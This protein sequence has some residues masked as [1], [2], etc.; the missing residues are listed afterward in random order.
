LVL[1]SAEG[2]FLPFGD[3]WRQRSATVLIFWSGSCPCVRRY[4]TR[5]DDLLERYPRDRVRVVAIS[6]NAGESFEEVLRIAKER[7][8]R[9]PIYR[10]ESGQVAR[11]VDAQSTPTVVVLDGEGR[12][13]FRGWMDNERLPEDP[14]REPWL[15]LALRGLL[16][17]RTY[18]QRTPTYG[19]T[20]TRSLTTAPPS[21]CCQEHIGGLP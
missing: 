4:Q 19:C 7:G 9:L 8:V 20:I 16:E 13:R 15:D 18:S 3:L 2:A 11:A 1:Q 17:H 12:V 21:P 5:M 14:K 10:D 6:S